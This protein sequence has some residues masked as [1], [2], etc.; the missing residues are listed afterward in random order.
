MEANEMKIAWSGT[1]TN[2]KA[3]PILINAMALI[4]RNHN[5]SHQS[6]I[7]QPSTSAFDLIT[8][9]VLGIGPKT[10]AWKKLAEKCGVDGRFIWHGWIQKDEA[11]KIVG[12]ADIFVIT[13]LK[14]LTSAVLMEAIGNGKPVVCLDHCGFATV[15]DETCGIKIPL[16]K[17]QD[18]IK[19]FAEAI[20]RLTN[21]EYRKQLSAGA[22]K[23]AEEY[24]WSANKA[25]LMNILNSCDKKVLVSA[26]ACS[27]YRGSEPGMGWNYL[28]AVAEHNEV[29]AIVEEEKWKSDIEKFIHNS[30]SF[31]L[32]PSLKN[33]HW[34]FIHKPRARWLRKIWPPSYYWFYRIWQWKA[35]KEALKL[36]KEVKFDLV[37]QLT[38]TG[39]REPGYL[40]KLD[41]PFA[42]GPIGGNVNVDWRLMP[43]AGLNG[44]LEYAARNIINWLHCHFLR[45]PRLA[46]RRASNYGMLMASTAE[47]AS[48]SK[49]LWNANAH[50]LCENGV[51]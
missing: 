8:V 24:R 5:N 35:Y 17:S 28:Q 47:I 6:S 15:I 25:K 44:A 41:A 37:Y 40:W 14:D 33:I 21:D 42:W 16:G 19:G 2:G 31:I 10:D 9:D 45:R 34:I 27:P 38:M 23:R 51:S 48:A 13:S 11:V 46:A 18:I 36:H 1:H 4:K 39:F 30:S 43:L 29:W 3:L 32:N 50:V 20:V 49:R 12:E 22:L 7:S 26:Y